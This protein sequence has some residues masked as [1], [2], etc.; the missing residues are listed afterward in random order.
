MNPFD[1]FFDYRSPY[2]Y[3]AHSQ[4]ATLAGTARFYPFDIRDVMQRVGNVPTSVVCQVKNQYVRADLQRWVGHYG[5][6]LV[7]HPRAL[8]ID[9]RRLLRATLAAGPADGAARAT[10]AGALFHALWRDAAA[11]DSASDVAKVLTDAGL[12]GHAIE[13]WIDNPATDAALD[14]CS[15]LAAERGVF[16]APTFF[17]G[18]D[19]YFGNDRLDFLRQRLNTAP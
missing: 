6:P 10:A 16:G 7:R 14:T 4:F 17:V 15:E 8:E 3:L 18:S 12:N 11:L 5:V 9:A 1:F 13:R 19:M 2:A